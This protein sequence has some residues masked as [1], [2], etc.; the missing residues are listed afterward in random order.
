MKLTLLPKI[1]FAA[2]LGLLLTAGLATRAGAHSGFQSYL[3]LDVSSDSLGGRVEM[4]IRDLNTALDLDLGGS[5]EEVLAGLQA[6]SD[7]VTRYVSDHLAIGDPN[8]TWQINFA[9]AELFFSDA[10][11]QDD[12]Y[13]LFP[14]VV[15]VPSNDV[16]RQFDITFDPFFDEIAGRDSLLLIGNDWEAGVIDNG[17]E[18]LV[19]FDDASRTQTIDL[20]DTSWTKTFD[21]SIDLGVNHIKSGTD[22]ILF[23]LVLVL[24]SVLIF[25]T[26]WEPT[27]TFGSALWRVLKVVTMFTVAHSITFTLAGL[28]LLPLPPARIVESIIAASIAAA[29]LHNIRPIAPNK[30]WVI[31][32]V[33][34]LFHGIG[35]ASVV[36]GLDVSRST[37]LL[38]LAGRNVGIEIGQSVVVMLTFPALFILRR[39]RFFH[40]FLLTASATLAVVSFGWMIERLFKVD[41]RV[42]KLVDP[43]VAWPRSFGYVLVLTFVAVGAYQYE[44]RNDRLISIE[45]S[46]G[47][48]D[49]DPGVD[50]ELVEA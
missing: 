23:V 11:E 42:A 27:P 43:L 40:P 50:R 12:N 19:A 25:S 8:A 49:D 9:A 13:V 2:L 38:S 1:L 15:D 29:A 3:Y 7:A 44:K 31:A 37:Q 21:A 10:P 47:I 20:G 41:L 17:R 33:F 5:N 32:F 45:S 14:F 6:N 16:P 4:P 34:G 30:E 46:S 24:P 18:V 48:T 22:H 39:T 26:R 28:N 36:S 35:F